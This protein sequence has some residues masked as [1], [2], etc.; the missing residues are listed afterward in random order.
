MIGYVCLFSF[1]KKP[2]WVFFLN[3]PSTVMHY[4]LN[5]SIPTTDSILNT[6]SWDFLTGGIVVVSTYIHKFTHST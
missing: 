3:P 5:C 4:P 2:S 6:D 1:P